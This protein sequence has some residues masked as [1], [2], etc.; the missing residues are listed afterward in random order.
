MNDNEGLKFD[1][2]LYGRV[3]CAAL[4]HNDCIY[5]GREGHH[6]MFPME[7]IGVLRCAKQ[8]FVTEFGYFVDRVTGLV[9]AEY[10]DQIWHKHTPKDQLMSEDLKKDGIMVL[11]HIEGYTYKEREVNKG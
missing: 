3:V 10:Y 6:V 11:R 4:L 9:I 5:M 8:G 7:P 2:N 1:P